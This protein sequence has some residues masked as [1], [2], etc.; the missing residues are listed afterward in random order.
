MAKGYAAPLDAS[1]AI[2][3]SAAAMY[4]AIRAVVTNR[5]GQTVAYPIA[6]SLNLWSVNQALWERYFPGESRPTTWQGLFR[7]MLRFEEE[8]NDDENLFLTEWDYEPMVK[9]VLRAFIQQRE[10]RGLGVDFNEASLRETL[11]LLSRVNGLMLEKGIDYLFEG[12]VHPE[13]EV[14]GEYAIFSQG[15]SGYS[16]YKATLDGYG[17]LM[18]FTF[19]EGETPFVPGYMLVLLVNP[20]SKQLDLALDFVAQAAKPESGMMRYYM[21]HESA[22]EPVENPDWKERMA[23]A[24]QE[25][26]ALEARLSDCD[27]AD[28]RQL[29]DDIAAAHAEEAWQEGRQWKISVQGIAGWQ[30]VAP[31]LR[32]FE[33]ASLLSEEM[34]AQM[35]VLVARYGA[36][37]LDLDGLLRQLD[38]VAR[39]IYL[40]Q[41]Q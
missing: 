38:Q 34:E 13:S 21:L 15:G 5:Q 19:G 9:A 8:N 4:P 24:R 7:T 35:D 12:D 32:F 16:T 25:R 28:R 1:P 33:N 40:E 30:A 10:A 2:T 22:T 17:G 39:Q 3:A 29:E 23:K 6:L 36:G 14:L 31:N 26:E 11:T 37:Q 27:P 18:P 41:A 20:L